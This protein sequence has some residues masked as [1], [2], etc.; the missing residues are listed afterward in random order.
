MNRRAVRRAVALGGVL[1]LGV[2]HFWILRL[3]GP[4]S[5]EQR[6]LWLQ[7]TCRAV[8]KSAG[9][10]LSVEGVP[11]TR[12]LVVSNHL[13]YLDI[14]ILGSAMPCLFVAK[15]EIARWPFF[16]RTARMGGTLFLDRSSMASA[17]G[18]AGQI[19]ERLR[20]P[21]PV[22]LFPEG[23]STDGSRVLRF[24]ARLI[25]PATAAGAPITAAAIR[26]QTGDGR[27]ERELCWYGDALFAPH[28][29]KVLGATDFSARVCFGLPRVYASRRAAAEQ[30]HDEIAAM[31]AEMQ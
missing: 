27:P 1:V 26:Y 5:L 31:R 7:Q 12:G 16:G 17:T 24:H 6:A 25:A 23:T 18:V 13:G 28:L 9:V 11:P 10:C 20:L 2:F 3:R 4:L 14:L 30:T 19:D 22:L 21:L 8:L 15:S 29:A